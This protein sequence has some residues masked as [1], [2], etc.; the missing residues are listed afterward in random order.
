MFFEKVV[1]QGSFKV[2]SCGGRSDAFQDFCIAL[3]EHQEDYVILLVDSEE[4]VVS[5]PWEHLRD[6]VGDNWQRPAGAH[7]DQAQLMVQSMES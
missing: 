5:G 3:R 4:A 6:R 7:D 1:P 2:V